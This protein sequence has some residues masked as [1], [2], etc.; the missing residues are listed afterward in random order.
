MRPVHPN[1]FKLGGR[2]KEEKRGRERMREDERE[3]DDSLP[4]FSSLRD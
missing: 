4:L 2:E 3:R 1:N